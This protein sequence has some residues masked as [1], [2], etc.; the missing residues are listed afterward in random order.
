MQLL[1]VDVLRICVCVSVCFSVSSQCMCYTMPY[2]KAD[3]FLISNNKN[4]SSVSNSI[5]SSANNTQ[6]K[7]GVRLT[8]QYKISSDCIFCVT[9]TLSMFT[10]NIGHSEWLLALCPLGTVG[11]TLFGPPWC[12][13]DASQV[14][15][16]GFEEGHHEGLFILRPAATNQ[17]CHTRIDTLCCRGRQR[18]QCNRSYY[19]PRFKSYMAMHRMKQSA[20]ESILGVPKVNFAC[21]VLSFL[22]ETTFVMSLLLHSVHNQFSCVTYLP[23]SSSLLQL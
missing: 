18:E 17:P 2:E 9:R 21:V 16:S 5:N 6:I 8:Q 1:I 12:W 3:N 10:C 19:K 23:F 13:P 20:S 22:T 4:Q 14:H 11:V 15:L 7:E